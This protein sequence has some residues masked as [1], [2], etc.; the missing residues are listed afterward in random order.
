MSTDFDDLSKLAWAQLWQLTI[1][2][3]IV[4]AAA[5]YL[6]R[7]RPQLAYA[8]WMLIIFKAIVPPVWGSPVGIF[9][10]LMVNEPG[11]R[12][13]T[14][15]TPMRSSPALP[16]SSTGARTADLTPVIE[17][18][19]GVN[20]GKVEAR[21]GLVRSLFSIWIVGVLLGLAFVLT[22]QVACFLIIRR[23][24]GPA[25]A[26]LSSEL[27]TLSDLLG[28]RQNVRLVVTSRPI[29]PAVFGLFRPTILLPE[30]LL[31]SQS[32]EQVRMILAHELIHVRRGDL[33]AGKLQLAAQLIWWFH[34]LVWWA[35]RQ[36][37]LE[38]ERCCDR[39]VLAGLECKPVTYAKALLCVLE[40]KRR[41]RSLVA[42]PGVRAMEVTSMRLESIMKDAA[43][44]PKRA[45]LVARLA[46]VAGAILLVP[47][48]GLVLRAGPSEEQTPNGDSP[49]AAQPIR[50]ASTAKDEALKPQASTA[51]QVPKPQASA[52]AQVPKPE[53]V[54]G[55]ERADSVLER[56]G[57]YVARGVL[58]NPLVP[59]I[60]QA[61]R[62]TGDQLAKVKQ[63]EVMRS[64]NL[65][66]APADIVLQLKTA[67]TKEAFFKKHQFE[68]N[69]AAG[70][71]LVEILTPPQCRR[72]E[73]IILDGDGVRAFRYPDVRADLHLTADQEVKIDAIIDGLF[74]KL[75]EIEKSPGGQPN[76]YESS[77]ALEGKVQ[78]LWKGAFAEVLALLDPAQLARWKTIVGEPFRVDEPE[79]K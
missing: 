7:N 75:R 64:A 36:A 23:S 38:R 18:L 2:G 8:L 17:N 73:Q 22:K 11:S 33:A 3:L 65:Q 46:F 15:P 27:G 25:D 45:A 77:M 44:H 24:R 53:E 61:L 13:V 41:L 1:V 66:R 79:P 52:A 20:L 19:P 28:M 67:G 63:L 21:T 68:V 47:G 31:A 49:K 50:G 43:T 26:Q 12:P 69:R 78:P 48:A 54:P 60:R 34:P 56:L 4:G 74:A 6:G 30:A 39:E 72:L 9:S 42:L 62:L 29:G 37:T 51:A 59:F 14:L 40:Q 55:T 5:R 58:T 16:G 35:N 10:R 71:G 32:P 57:D 70:K 76:D